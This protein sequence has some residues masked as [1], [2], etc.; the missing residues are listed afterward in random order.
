MD[1]SSD[2]QEKSLTRGLE[3]GYESETLW[4]KSLLIIAQNNAIKTNYIEARIDKT[5][6]NSKCRVCGDRDEKISHMIS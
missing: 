5:Q 2:K 4:K 6:Q 1:I 3:H